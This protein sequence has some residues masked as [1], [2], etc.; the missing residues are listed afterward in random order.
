[1]LKNIPPHLPCMMV[2]LILGYEHTIKFTRL[3]FIS[4]AEIAK[5]FMITEA[6]ITP[7]KE[8]AKD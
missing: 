4:F 7:E 3:T 6:R 1:M 8:K 5:V 2:H